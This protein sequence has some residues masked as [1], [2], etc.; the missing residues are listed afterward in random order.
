MIK[1]FSISIIGLM[2]VTLASVPS[3]AEGSPENPIAQWVQLHGVEHESAIRSSLGR[4]ANA[5]G[6]SPKAMAQAYLDEYRAAHEGAEI[7]GIDGS[8]HQ[9]GIDAIG[10]EP[11]R[12]VHT[13]SVRLP[14]A[15]RKGD[16]FYHQSNTWG[17]EHGH[18]GLYRWKG[19][20]VEAANSDL[21]VIRTKIAR[22]RSDGTVR[23]MRKVPKGTYV[24]QRENLGKPARDK[25]T[26]WA[27][28]R[29]G[30]NYRAWWRHNRTWSAPY[31]CSQLVWAAYDRAGYDLDPTDSWDVN[32]RV[33]PIELA[34]AYRVY[35]YKRAGM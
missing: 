21:G 12:A 30:A 13:G 14:N 18:V 5:A 11:V 8:V 26:D 9:V 28:G 25:I 31:N 17:Y 34:T 20:V 16:F 10:V 7:K 2:A 27:N 29:V 19:T 4:D 24:L 3:Y 15:D 33:Y 6:V 32:V 35:Y 1:L 23:V 22:R